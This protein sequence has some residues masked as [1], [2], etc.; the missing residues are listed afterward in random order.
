MKPYQVIIAEDDFRVANIWKEFT[1]STPGF[2]VIADAKTGEE[3][4]GLIRKNQVDL[5]IMDVYM[6][7]LDGVRLLYEIRKLAVPIDVI[8]ITAAKEANIIQKIVRM[9]VI[10]Y[11][12]KPCA[13]ERFT[14]ALNRFKYFRAAFNHPELEQ[15]KI[16][17]ILYQTTEAPLNQLRSLPKGLQ[18]ITLNR[19]LVCF[20]NNPFS[21]SAEEISKSTGL[22]AATVQRYL[23]HL[24]SQ[25]TIKKE[26]TYGS[27]GRPEHKY[28]KIET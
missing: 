10:D 4:L 7:D 5:V 13:F 26:L 3:A 11:I 22:S 28:S 24:A 2:Q 14:M 20:E 25:D 6:P 21:Q 9:G 8:A 19:I 18:E 1:D 15:D 12:I 17:S 16:D 23:R 27:Q